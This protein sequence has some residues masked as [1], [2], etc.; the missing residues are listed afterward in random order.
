MTY[1]PIQLDSLSSREHV[2]DAVN[3]LY[4]G[5]DDENIDLVDSAIVHS[6][7]V[8]I[9]MGD[10]VTQGWDNLRDH[11]LNNVM[12][13]PTTHQLTNFRVIFDR[14]TSARLTARCVAHHSSEEKGYYAVG[15]LFEVDLV[16]D[17]ADD[18]WKILHLTMKLKWKN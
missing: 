6:N 14:T 5:L 2:I 10:K 3:R 4:T 18:L 13:V 1:Y 7:E 17:E 9:R 12:P 16:Y 15:G 11:L 8:S